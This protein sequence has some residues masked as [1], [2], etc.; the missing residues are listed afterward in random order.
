[1]FRNRLELKIAAG[2][3]TRRN[4]GISAPSNP[5]APAQSA[6]QVFRFD[7]LIVIFALTHFVE[8]VAEVAVIS[9]AFPL[10]ADKGA[11]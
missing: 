1:V 5:A 9:T 10:G 8:S 11:V 4:P 7:Q 3:N 6:M 2:H